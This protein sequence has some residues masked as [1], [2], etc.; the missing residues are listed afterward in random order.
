MSRIETA[1]ARFESNFLLLLLSAQFE[2]LSARDLH[3]TA[4]LNSDY[5][6]T[7]P[8][9]VDWEKAAN[10]N[11]VIFRWGER[12][13]VAVAEQIRMVRGTYALSLRLC[14]VHP[15]IMYTFVLTTM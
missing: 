8:I 12:G 11:A 13:K 10:T 4:A 9:D 2:G 6:L 14:I 1:T 7:L 5:L 3:L 15:H